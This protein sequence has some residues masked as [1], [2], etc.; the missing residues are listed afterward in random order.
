MLPLQ[1]QKG[2]DGGIGRHAGLKILWPVMAVRV[3]FPLRVLQKFAFLQGGLFCIRSR[4][5]V[6]RGRCG[7]VVC[8]FK[9]RHCCCATNDNKL[10]NSTSNKFGY[11]CLISYLK[12]SVSMPIILLL[13]CSNLRRPF[14]PIGVEDKRNVGA[15]KGLKFF[16]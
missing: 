4:E 13:L 10:D 15:N 12:P 1:L 7:R 9:N 11:Y 16:P 5:S 2:S 3:R 6:S 14:D 8:K